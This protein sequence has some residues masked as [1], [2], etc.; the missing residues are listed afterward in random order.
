VLL[1]AMAPEFYARLRDAPEST[2]GTVFD[3]I[4]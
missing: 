1:V 3:W 2:L 4:A